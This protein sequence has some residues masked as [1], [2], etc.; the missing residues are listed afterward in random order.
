MLRPELCKTRGISPARPGVYPAL[1]CPLF[2][3]ISCCF[4]CSM[5]VISS[6][7]CFLGG[8]LWA[9]ERGCS[10]VI[11]PQWFCFQLSK[12]KAKLTEL[13]SQQVQSL[14]GT[15]GAQEVVKYKL[16]G[17]KGWVLIFSMSFM[18][19]KLHKTQD[20]SGNTAHASPKG[21]F[22]IPAW[23]DWLE[24]SWCTLSL[25]SLAGQKAELV[26]L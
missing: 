4:D 9:P 15:W 12:V 19:Q 14:V 18:L 3:W 23:W 24:D 6:L 5:R 10:E 8:F 2:N 17:P 13:S 1:L 20:I 11:I 22:P 26:F 7:L 25:Q 21:I 16:K